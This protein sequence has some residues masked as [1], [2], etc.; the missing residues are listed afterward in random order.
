MFEEQDV[1]VPQ[2]PQYPP[3]LP[4]P[5]LPSPPLPLYL[6]EIVG[7]V[8]THVGSGL[9]SEVDAAFNVLLSL[10]KAD[11]DGMRRFDV[12]IKAWH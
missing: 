6:Q 3:S 4:S 5:P 10:V 1:S 2:S 7:A 12:F 8:V 11:V 9:P